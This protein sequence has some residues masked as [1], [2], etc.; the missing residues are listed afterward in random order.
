MFYNYNALHTERTDFGT[1]GNNIE[2]YEQKM[3]NAIACVKAGEALLND[4]VLDRSFWCEDAHYSAISLLYNIYIFIYVPHVSSWYAFNDQGSRGYICLLNDRDHISVLQRVNGQPTIPC[5]AFR[6]RLSRISVGWN[7]IRS[8]I[9][10]NYPFTYVWFW[11]NGVAEVNINS[12]FCT[13]LNKDAEIFDT[14]SKMNALLE[15]SKIKNNK[16]QQ[17]PDC[18]LMFADLKKHNKCRM[19]FVIDSNALAASVLGTDVDSQ[20]NVSVAAT[21]KNKTERCLNCK[22]MFVDLKKHSKCRG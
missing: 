6:H 19:K 3:R 1:H 9:T 11:P 16:T 12:N 15:T 17:C 13:P 7:D 2:L 14:I 8:H 22:L 21:T 20:V 10:R 5:S 4:D 18:K